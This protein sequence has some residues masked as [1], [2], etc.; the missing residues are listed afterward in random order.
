MIVTARKGARGPLRL[1]TPFVLHGAAAHR[2][3]GE[4]LTPQAQDVLR[5]GAAI[6][7]DASSF[8]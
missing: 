1:L 3:D 8:R 2:G 4:D 7:L 6:P 5:H